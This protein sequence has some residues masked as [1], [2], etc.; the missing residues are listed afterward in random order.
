M[1]KQYKKRKKTARQQKILWRFYEKKRE[2]ANE[3][4]NIARVG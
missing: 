1:K 2:V 4:N 3:I